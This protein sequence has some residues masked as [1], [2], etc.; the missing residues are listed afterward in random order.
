[1]QN[2]TSGP[3]G[4]NSTPSG[5]A[6]HAPGAEKGGAGAAGEGG[7]S[8]DD[9]LIAEAE[10]G[11]DPASIVVDEATLAGIGFTLSGSLCPTSSWPDDFD[12][13]KLPSLSDFYVRSNED[14]G[15]EAVLSTVDE[16]DNVVEV[17]P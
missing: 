14:G 17:V 2:P 8:S 3:G 1:E 10:R 6:T 7:A 5:G 13:S 9:S 4:R 16:G 15:L 11:I 12:W